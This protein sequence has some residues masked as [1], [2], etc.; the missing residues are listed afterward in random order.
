MLQKVW[1]ITS[2]N[3]LQKLHVNVPGAVFVDYD[4]SVGSTGGLAAPYP[5]TRNPNET[6]PVTDGWVVAQIVVTSDSAD[7]LDSLELTP[8]DGQK[9][10]QGVNFTVKN[11]DAKLKGSML[12]QVFLTEKSTLRDFH[13]R[14]AE[15]VVGELVLVQDD[16][17]AV[18][19][20]G[21]HHAG[22]LHVSSTQ[23]FSLH[24]LG[25]EAQTAGI[26]QVQVPFIQAH[27]C[28]ILLAGTHHA[29]T[30]VS[31]AAISAPQV[32]AGVVVSGDVEVQTSKL[33]AEAMTS[34]I[35]LR[36]SVRVLGDGQVD[37]QVGKVA[38]LGEI[39]TGDI[40]SDKASM[41]F[42][43]A[44]RAL[45]NTERLHVS[46]P[47]FGTVE[48]TNAIEPELLNPF[49]NWFW[50]SRTDI[51]RPAAV[52]WATTGIQPYKFRDPPQRQPIAV[53]HRVKASE[54]LKPELTR[55]GEYSWTTIGL[56][57]GA[58]AVGAIALRR[59]TSRLA[60]GRYSRCR[61]DTMEK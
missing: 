57:T 38:G 28:V 13:T 16:A 2:V 40:T 42:G 52:D 49:V 17:E 59:R 43:L 12:T 11:R 39:I 15:T 41:S 7:I 44:G 27:N 51:V 34:L 35:G 56:T 9:G 30:V 24:T 20:I 45:I 4:A 55:A 1:T 53:N 21:V 54:R 10:E 19:N 60:K 50:R 18:V 46:V 58:L 8:Q 6:I 26:A 3:Q 32:Y 31:A 14:S 23:G 29:A 22:I 25:V 37:M 61:S 33:T 5:L 47:F 48:Y 36:G